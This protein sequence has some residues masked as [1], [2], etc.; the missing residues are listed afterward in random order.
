M[1][2]MQAVVVLWYQ[3]S[4]VT[5]GRAGSRLSRL[6]MSP[7]QVQLRTAWC[8]PSELLAG[9]LTQLSGTSSSLLRPCTQ[10]VQV[11][12][13]ARH[14]TCSQQ[15]LEMFANGPCPLKTAGKPFDKL[16]TLSDPR[17]SVFSESQ[18]HCWWQRKYNTI[19]SQVCGISDLSRSGM[20]ECLQTMCC[21]T[22]VAYDVVCLYA[23]CH[24]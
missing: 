8:L 2:V 15:L 16:L 14:S 1:A 9:L 21:A 22:A 13:A 18:R 20:P 23:G 19:H 5:H 3:A 11:V 7:D 12:F 10:P 24:N 17:Q 4:R 6:A